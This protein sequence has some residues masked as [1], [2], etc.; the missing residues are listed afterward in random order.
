M[1]DLA[2]RIRVLRYVIQSVTANI[3]Q[4]LASLI[5][6]FLIIYIYTVF[7]FLMYQDEYRFPDGEDHSC[8]N[9]RRCYWGHIDFGMRAGPIWPDQEVLSWDKHMF[10]ITY[11]LFVILIVVAIVTG[12]IIDTFAN[13]RENNDF[14]QN[15]TKNRCFV[16]NMPRELFERH[17]I[18]FMTHV[19]RDHN[20]WKY[21]YYIMYLKEKKQTK[22]TGIEAYIISLVDSSKISYFPMNRAIQMVDTEEDQLELLTEKVDSLNERLENR[23]DRKSVV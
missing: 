2:L 7:G 10:G 4:V 14:I 15:D 21:T 6:A 23:E 13:M 22:Y 17:H 16:C 18:N 8:E 12:I 5:M 9:L 11:N 3:G 19:K 20:M 1:L